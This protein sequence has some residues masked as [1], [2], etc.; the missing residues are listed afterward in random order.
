MRRPVPA[1]DST[2]QL[3]SGGYASAQL[4]HLSDGFAALTGNS[5]PTFSEL[6][7]DFA[8]LLVFID[9]PNLRYAEQVVA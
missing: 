9:R 3:R 4:R 2:A 7:G 5:R 8:G 6:D 1:Y